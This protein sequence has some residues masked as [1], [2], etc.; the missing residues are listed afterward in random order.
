MPL[1]AGAAVHIWNNWP[2]DKLS[3][4]LESIYAIIGAWLS[5]L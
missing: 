2:T 1:L 3:A 4:N 5:R